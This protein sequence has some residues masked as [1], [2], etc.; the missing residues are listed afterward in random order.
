[1]SLSKFLLLVFV[2]LFTSV[3][4]SGLLGNFLKNKADFPSDR[5][6]SWSDEVQGI[7]HDD[8]N[9]FISQKNALWRIPADLNLN[10]SFSGR[11]KSIGIARVEIPANLRKQGYYHMGDIDHYQ[12]HIYVPV[13][14]H[15]RP[16]KLLKFDAQT[17]QLKGVADFWAHQHHAP[18]VAINPETGILY[19]SDFTPAKKIGLYAYKMIDD[20]K[21]FRLEHATRLVLKNKTGDKLLKVR[22]IQGGEFDLQT[23]TLML[24]SDTSSGGILG[25]DM[26]TG[27]FKFSHRVDYRPGFPHYE[28]LEG[29][30]IWRKNEHNS[31]GVEGA[32]HLLMLDNDVNGDD[33]YLKHYDF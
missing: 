28:E 1:M 5:S 26:D 12:G 23:R 25:F 32:I 6:F 18:Y 8:Y 7:T 22:N 31:D 21:G 19:S 17:M 10:H 20:E 2:F 27:N 24:V 3:G 4:H 15:H 30:T 29:I 14:G 13:E 33:V 11:E 16:Y 9:W